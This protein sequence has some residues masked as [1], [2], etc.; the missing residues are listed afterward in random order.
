MF[1]PG[2]HSHLNINVGFYT[3]VYG[4]GVAPTDTNLGTVTCENG[5]YEYTVGALDNFWR[6][7]EN[8]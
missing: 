4:L 6:S 5:D 7:V 3:S 1:K 8:F 2:D